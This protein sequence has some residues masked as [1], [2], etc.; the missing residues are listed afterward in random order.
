LIKRKNFTSLSILIVISF[1]IILPIANVFAALG[2]PV[3]STYSGHAGDTISV[4]GGPFSVSL[5]TPIEIYWDAV[6]GSKGHLLN[7]TSG[8]IDG[9]YTVQ[10]IIPENSLGTH[11]IWV[12]DTATGI[13]FWSL[14]LPCGWVLFPGHC[15]ST[16]FTSS[17]TESAEEIPCW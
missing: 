7:T 15:G 13:H 2:T 9:S 12:K 8:R 6:D 10:V 14:F 4:S 3:L 16:S 1:S 5:G 17:S 11:L